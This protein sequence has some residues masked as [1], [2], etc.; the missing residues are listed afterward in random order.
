MAKTRREKYSKWLDSEGWRHSGSTSDHGM[1]AF[2]G[3]FGG[4]AACLVFSIFTVIFGDI[5]TPGWHR[6]EETD[7]MAPWYEP[8]LTVICT[9]AFLA[10]LI[11]EPV[12]AWIENLRRLTVGLSQGQLDAVHTWKSLPSNEKKKLR[13]SLLDFLE[14][15][16]SHNA[17]FRKHSD[18]WSDLKYSILERDRVLAE[19]SALTAGDEVKQLVDSVKHETNQLRKEA[20]P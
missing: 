7:I 13:S 5:I 12:Q 9:L 3:V 15:D 20:Q 1:W 6:T 8:G 17:I 11:G 14:L 4:A 10:M 18:T 16:N 19:Y 2:M